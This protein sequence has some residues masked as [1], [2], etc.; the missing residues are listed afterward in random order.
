[1]AVVT[2][3]P[4][5]GVAVTRPDV[6]GPETTVGELRTLFLDD[7]MHMALLVDGARLVATVERRDLRPGLPDDLPAH[8]VGTLR[9]RTVPPDASA[10][11]LLDWMRQSRRRRLA[12]TDGH[13]TLL[14]LVCLKANGRGFCSD[15]DVTSRRLEPS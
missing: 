6:L 8:A 1:M 11:A 7:H 3:V 5:T 2:A 15:D 9:G 13:G 4:V 12:V 14:G 10:V